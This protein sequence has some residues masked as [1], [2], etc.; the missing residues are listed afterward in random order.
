MAP[1]SVHPTG[2]IYSWYWGEL[3]P[4]F[5][6]HAP[7]QTIPTWL[8]ELIQQRPVSQ[9]PSMAVNVHSTRYAQCA[10]ESEVGKVALA[11]VGER[12]H[13]LNRAAFALGQ[14]VGSGEIDVDGV[15]DALLGAAALVGLDEPEASKTIASGLMAG[16]AQPR[17]FV[18]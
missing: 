16:T 11:P 12:N 9:G 18:R 7:L 10:L 8:R 2:P 4:Y 5:G 1:P 15:I 17:R 14:L 6:A 13:T 3:D